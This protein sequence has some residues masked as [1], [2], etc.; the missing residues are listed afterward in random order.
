[1]KAGDA[2]VRG[3]DDCHGPPRFSV[4]AAT[5]SNHRAEA[6][7]PPGRASARAHPKEPTFP[8]V[9]LTSPPK[10]RTF[11]AVETTVSSTGGNASGGGDHGLL[12]RRRSSGS[13]DHAVLGISR[14][15]RCRP[16]PPAPACGRGWGPAGSAHGRRCSRRGT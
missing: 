7:R 12:H 9:V 6:G 11:P 1:M 14:G 13:G 2:S 3:G 10:E 5:F 16:R 15:D 4:V 8:P